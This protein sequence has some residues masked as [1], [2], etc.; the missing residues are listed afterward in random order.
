MSSSGSSGSA[1]ALQ[2]HLAAAEKSPEEAEEERERAEEDMEAGDKHIQSFDDQLES[3]GDG[4]EGFRHKD[5]AAAKDKRKKPRE[6]E[7]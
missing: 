3:G 5:K 4:A 7:L 2:G 1:L 6:N